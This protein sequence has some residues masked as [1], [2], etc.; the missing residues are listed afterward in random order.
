MKTGYLI[1]VFFFCFFFFVFFCF[2]LFCF[3]LFCFFGG[4][5]LFCFLEGGKI[6][7]TDCLLKIERRSEKKLDQ[8]IF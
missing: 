3:V 8:P 2:V 4:C 5:F 1:K 7:F 6:L